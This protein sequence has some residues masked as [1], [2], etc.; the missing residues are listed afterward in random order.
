MN[1]SVFIRTFLYPLRYYLAG[2]LAWTLFYALYGTAKPYLIKQLVDTTAQGGSVETLTFYALLFVGL[3][4]SYELFYQL[5]DLCD[6][7]YKPLF[8]NY[9]A[10]TLV[11]HV[12]DQDYR[13][14]QNQ[15]AGNIAAKISDVVNFAPEIVK[16]IIDNYITNAVTVLMG[17]FLLSQVHIYFAI[18]LGVWAFFFVLISVGTVSRFSYLSNNSAE[19]GARI[20]AAIVDVLGNM[21]TIKLFSSKKYE[22]KRL[23]HYMQNYY[24]NFQRRRWFLFKLYTLQ[25][26][27]YE[28]Y[29]GS[30]LFLLIYLYSGGLVSAGDFALILTLNLWIV[31]CMWDMSDKMRTLSEHWG[32][33][34]QA[35][36]VIYIPFEV[37]DLPGAKD[38]EVTRGEIIF[39]N[40]T[41]QYEGAS[42]LFTK[43]SVVI[44]PQEKVGLVGYSGSG[45]S[46]FARL[47]LRIYD[48]NSGR[49][50]IDGQDISTVTQ[51]S[52]RQS[53]G[54]YPQD[55]SLFH[56][57][58]IANIKYGNRKATDEEVVTVARKVHAD[59]FIRASEHGYAT[60][61]GERGMKLSGGQRQRIALARAILKD[62]PI[63]IMDEATSQLDSETERIIQESLDGIMRNKTTIVIAHRLSTLLHMDRILV[64]DKGSI[65]QE[66]THEELVQQPGLYQTLWQ[67]QICGFLPQTRDA[68]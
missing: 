12:L 39:E 47:I 49:I 14:F 29:Q 57:S 9:I 67:S 5:Y 35:L 45:K 54:I 8:K 18:A 34:D 58:I 15:F 20:V 4:L 46:T 52:L 59:E 26:F 33:V 37:R 6:M 22:L 32:A 25:A 36:K 65:V 17:M 62:A 16:I 61:V 66:G 60:E 2:P 28:L 56:R 11:Q 51:E 38:L 55:P 19:A 53:I 24:V 68:A 63:M 44:K 3:M 10:H 13:Y 43:K 64:F 23:G 40:V 30:C 42:P 27:S 7:R 21:L 48:V 31:D 1:V 50:L 41:F